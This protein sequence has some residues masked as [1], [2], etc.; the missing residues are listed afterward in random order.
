MGGGRGLALVMAQSPFYC[1]S[2]P[3]PASAQP[4]QSAD[5]PGKEYGPPQRHPR[6]KGRHDTLFDPLCGCSE[7]HCG[8]YSSSVFLFVQMMVTDQ[9]LAFL[10]PLHLVSNYCADGF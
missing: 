4:R 8:S 2:P 7:T 1:P 9:V 5:G 10:K 6:P 3:R